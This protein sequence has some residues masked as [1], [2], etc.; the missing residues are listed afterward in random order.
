MLKTF[1]KTKNPRN[2]LASALSYP[3]GTK[4]S[5]AAKQFD[6]LLNLTSVQSNLAKGRITEQSPLL[7]A[8]GFLQS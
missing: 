1:K 8:N 4:Q 3:I 5:P 6:A 2:G 7:D